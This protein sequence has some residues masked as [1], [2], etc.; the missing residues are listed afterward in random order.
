MPNK[1]T[2]IKQTYQKVAYYRGVQLAG[3]GDLDGAKQLF[4]KSLDNDFDARTSA[5]AN[6][7]L[8]EIAH[9]QKKFRES[10]Q[11]LTKFLRTANH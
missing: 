5:L 7:G 11:H 3:D 4:Y 8:G 9:Q 2:K 6:Y 10:N 1:T